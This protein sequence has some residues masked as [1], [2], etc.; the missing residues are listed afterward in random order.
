MPDDDVIRTARER[1]TEALDAE[2][3]NRAQADE[4]LRFAALEQWDENVA[5]ARRLEGRPV[6]VMD[7]IGQVVRQVTGDARLNPPGIVVRPV[8]SGSDPAVA[9]TLTGLIRNI[10][11]SSSADTAYISALES[12]ARCGMGFLRVTYDYTHDGSFDMEL[13]IENIRSPFAVLFDPFAQ[14]PT[15]SDAEYCFVSELIP[16]KTFERKYPK[17]SLTDWDGAQSTGEWAGWREG[18]AV[19]IA[20]YWTREMER[21]KLVRLADGRVLNATRLGADAVKEQVLRVQQETG[22][23][24]VQERDC[25][26]P[27]VT[28]RR[29]NG[30]AELE[31]PY[32]WPGMYI[33]VV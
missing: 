13:R 11:A 20:D 18:N 28:M 22:L 12:A 9:E 15:R 26:I 7:R 21:Q 31:E 25:D 5:A 14:D 19:R 24:D 1:W 8:D 6:L 16:I 30:V 29:I 23:A 4:D 32:T 10:E 33:P 17:A 3:P 2:L 27:I